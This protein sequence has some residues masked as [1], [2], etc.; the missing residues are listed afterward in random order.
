LKLQEINLT[1]SYDKHLPVIDNT[2]NKITNSE[3]KLDFSNTLFVCVQHLLATTNY[4][5][6]SLLNLGANVKNVHIMGKPYSTCDTVVDSLIANGYNYY[7]HP[8]QQSIGNFNNTFYH[9][10]DKM[11]TDIMQQLSHDSSIKLIVILDD[12]GSC[13]C[14]VPSY[15][16]DNYNVIGVEQTAS[17]IAKIK[18]QIPPLPI[19]DVATSATKK[20][21]ESPMI[22]D[23]VVRKLELVLPIITKK[24]L[25]CGVIGLGAI[26]NAVINKLLTLGH[27]VITY[28]KD[29][30]N[31]D[32]KNAISYDDVNQLIYDCEYIFGC[33]GN[34]VTSGVDFSQINSEKYFISCS[35]HDIEFLS[36]INYIK[37]TIDDINITDN[38]DIVCTV[39]KKAKINILRKGY[40]INFDRTGE[41]VEAHNIQL[42]RGLLFGGVLQAIAFY[43]QSYNQYLR[44]YKIYMLAPDIQKFVID[45]WVIHGSK[46]FTDNLYI[47]K[48]QDFNWIINNSGGILLR[49][50]W[51]IDTFK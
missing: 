13:I 49:N 18:S 47:N 40:P 14:R 9:Y 28:D 10:I 19:I 20:L 1:L 44:E 5:L 27:K 41:S 17:G 45:N 6:D 24:K 21:I 33:S 3:Y 38:G 30:I 23:A 51:I 25:I 12:G 37:Q 2:V 4:M 26:G 7:H 31:L 11:W 48:F 43:N 34:D 39:N 42:T 35:S 16:V 32:N 22:A 46:K 15:I 50:Q 29:N 36:L 8:D